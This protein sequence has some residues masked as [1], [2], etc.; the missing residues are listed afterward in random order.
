MVY[1]V[2]NVSDD[3][4]E[5]IVGKAMLTMTEGNNKIRRDE[6]TD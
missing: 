5:K 4:I 6:L 2:Q 3:I 1:K